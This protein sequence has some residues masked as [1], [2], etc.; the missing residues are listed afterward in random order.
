MGRPSKYTEALAQQ[1]F[2]YIRDGLT[3]ED[4]ACLAGISDSTF[5][6]WKHENE[7][8]REAI[9]KAWIANKHEHI[10]V[11]RAREKNWQASAWW[12]E[13]RFQDEFALNRDKPVSDE[14]L[15]KVILAAAKVMEENV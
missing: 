15:R 5:H 12:L 9:K 4:A 7:D 8:F 11:V 1:I 6:R 13:R 14:E 10:K 2:E 3:Q